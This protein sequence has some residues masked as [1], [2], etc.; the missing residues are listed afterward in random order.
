MSAF[1]SRIIS[2][3]FSV[4]YKTY[5]VWIQL[6]Q[7]AS[8]PASPNSQCFLIHWVVVSFAPEG[9]GIQGLG[10]GG[11]GGP[12]SPRLVKVGKNGIGELQRPC[13]TAEILDSKIR[14][15]ET[16]ATAGVFPQL[17]APWA[18]IFGPLLDRAGATR[19]PDRSSLFS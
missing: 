13:L 17:L 14:R 7:S 4:A 6:S 10:F 3:S 12:I 9:L 16:A 18:S 15:S 11:M 19:L 2:W 1:L 5:D 8:V